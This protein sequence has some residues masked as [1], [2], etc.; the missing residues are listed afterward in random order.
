MTP[1]SIFA[2]SNSNDHVQAKVPQSTKIAVVVPCYRVA[3]T[4]L[5][6]I[7]AMPLQISAIYCVDDSCPE[8]SGDRI[9]QN[10]RDPRV[11]V[12][13]H[14]KNT[15]V[16]GAVITGYRQAIADCCDIVVK[17]DGDG[18]MSPALIMPLIRPIASGAADY[19][20]GNRFWNVADVKEMPLTGWP[21]MHS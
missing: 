6:V 17:V 19:C 11:K 12:L 9:E 21:E 13:R 16:G 7:A 5:N 15:G 18:Q 4:V 20:K 8:R 10:C 1:Q 2:D 14:A 3:S